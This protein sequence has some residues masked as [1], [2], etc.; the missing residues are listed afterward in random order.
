[1][2]IV[3]L[4]GEAMRRQKNVPV[5][6]KVLFSNIPAFFPSFFGLFPKSAWGKM[7]VFNISFMLRGY[8]L[9][10]SHIWLISPLCCRFFCKK[11]YLRA[12]PSKTCATHVEQSRTISEKYG[13][14]WV[15]R[16]TSDGTW[17]ERGQNVWGRVCGGPRAENVLNR[18]SEGG[19]PEGAWRG[20]PDPNWPLKSSRI[21]TNILKNHWTHERNLVQHPKQ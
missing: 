1:M 4:L 5:F 19:F 2:D 7:E 15:E 17:A 16:G 10:I 20:S 6:E 14:T 3:S 9:K 11:K 12:S 13:G 18:W 21:N 8:I